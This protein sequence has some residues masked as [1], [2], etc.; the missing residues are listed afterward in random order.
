MSPFPSSLTHKLSLLKYG[1][2]AIR[3]RDGRGPGQGEGASQEGDQGDHRP[4]DDA[5]P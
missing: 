3:R 1:N 2:R 4:G 5:Q